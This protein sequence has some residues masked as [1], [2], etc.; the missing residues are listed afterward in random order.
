MYKTGDLV[1]WLPDGNIDFLGR[2]DFQVKVRGFRIELGEI[3]NALQK[4]TA[5]KDAVVLAKNAPDN[6]TYLVAYYTVKGNTDIS[7]DSVKATLNGQ[8]P[9]YMVPEF[10]VKLKEFPLTSNGKIDRK[11]LPE[12]NLR[13]KNMLHRMRG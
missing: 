10:F 2:M 8:L 6:T 3:E 12:P 9:E 13:E 5:I 7:Y 11:N 1:K 4:I